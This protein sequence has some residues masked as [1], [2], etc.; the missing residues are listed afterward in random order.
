VGNRLRGLTPVRETQLNVRRPESKHLADLLEEMA[1]EAPDR[2]FVVCGDR[3]LTYR[4]FEQRVSRIARG[5]YGLGVRPGS[6]VALLMSNRLEWLDISFATHQLGATVAPLST[7]YR[8]WDLD[9]GLRQSDAEVLVTLPSFRGNSYL[10]F[11][12]ELGRDTFPSLKQVV[13]LAESA[14]AGML[15]F[16]ELLRAGSGV[17]QAEVEACHHQ[18]SAH[19]LAYILYTSGTTARPKGVMVEHLGICENAWSMG[20]RLHLTPDDRVW[21]VVPLA[22]GFGSENALPV[23]LTHRATIVLQEHFDAGHALGLFER[24]RVTAIY[25]MPNMTLALVD[26]PDHGTRDLSSLRT[27]IT[28]GTREELRRAIEDVPVPFINNAYG[29]TENYGNTCLTDC[30]MDAETRMTCQGQ[31]LPGMDVRVVDPETGEPVA[32]GTPGELLVGGYVVPGYWRDPE[33]TRETFPGGLYRTGDLAYFDEH[34]NMHYVAR[35]KDMIKSGGINVA[36]A[37]V[38]D[39]LVTHPLVREAY[40]LGVTDPEKGEVLMAFVQLAPDAS[41]SEAELIAWS[42]ARIASYK[43]PQ[44]WRFVSEAEV[45]RTSTGKVNKVDLRTLLDPPP[46]A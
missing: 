7:F 18:V 32:P 42:R 36:P 17:T 40:V 19:D 41:L 2:E 4:A 33:R 44:R 46:P 28:L 12:A 35:I 22:W 29:A 1:A 13:V 39:F 34:G 37:E 43:I 27:G 5:L 38:E 8:S 16:P 31:P 23:T 45:P 24:E 15:T 20:E 9:Y 3:R 30:D 6:R 21:V 25:A 11:L 10:D 14:P 26:H